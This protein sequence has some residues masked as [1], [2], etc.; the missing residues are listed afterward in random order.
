[1]TGFES[2]LLK[3][4]VAFLFSICLWRYY[5]NGGRPMRSLI[6]RLSL[7]CTLLSFA[8]AIVFVN[9][10]FDKSLNDSILDIFNNIFC[11]F[12]GVFVVFAYKNRLFK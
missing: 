4:L 5:N 2:Y 8:T 6:K 10:A 9:L 11:T 1:M 12:V 3:A 7:A